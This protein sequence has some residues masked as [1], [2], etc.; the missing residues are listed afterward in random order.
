M[1]VVVEGNCFVSGRIERCCVGIE[2][3]RIV[4]VARVLE[5]DRKFDFGSKLIIP[6]ATDCHVHFRDPGM[7]QKEDFASG[8]LAAVHGGVTCVFDM[9]NTKPATTTME[10]LEEKR[11]IASAKSMVDFGLFAGMLPGVDVQAL[12]PK[13]IGFK[14]Y[15]AGT[16]GD[17]LIPSLES[18][19]KEIAAVA[20]SGKVL[21]VHA[22][23]ES[24]RRKDPEKDLGD[25]L[26]NRGN[27]CETSAIRKV[28]QAASACKLHVCHVSAR[29]SLPL[30][31]KGANLTTE[32]SPHHLLLDRASNLGTRGKVNPPLRRREDRQAMFQ[33]LKNG[34]FDIVASDHAPHTLEDKDEDFEYAPTGMPGV[35]TML[36]LMLQ[37]VRDRHIALEDLVKRLC[38]RPGQIFGVPKGRIEPGYDA[39]LVVI[40]MME[41]SEIRADRLH[42]RCGWTA[43]EGMPAVFP[44]A[45]FLRGEIVVENGS[46]A[47]DRRGRGVIDASR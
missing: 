17:L 9:P 38:E 4:R 32:V 39:D 2:N 11:G 47:G 41:G 3:G 36:P 22:E 25:H 14:I 27:E 42:S 31:P 33:A 34:E 12:A 7:T 44:K 30:L 8:S 10:A 46:V 24:L 43:F 26:K 5:G 23:D 21:A 37:L 20:A 28:R 19:K 6:G 29:E 35:E 18:V 16:T 15:M 45:V 13:C 1:E 40:D